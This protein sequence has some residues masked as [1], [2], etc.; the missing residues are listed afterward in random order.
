M[1]K[2]PYNVLLVNLARLY[3]GAEVRVL[4]LAAALQD[5]VE[6]CSVAVLQG[7]ALHVR[8][9]K[10][11]LPF[12]S[13]PMTRS[14]PR[15]LPAL[16]NIIRHG[17]YQIVDAHNVQSIL[18]GHFSGFA[19]GAKGRVTTVHSDFGAET[20]GIKGKFYESVLLLDRLLARQFVN[21]TEV[22]QIKAGKHRLGARSTLIPNAVAVPEPVTTETDFTIR[23]EW[24]FENTDFVVGIVARL[25]PIKGHAYLIEAMTLLADLPCIKL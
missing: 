14:N 22:L 15:L 6:N 12:V 5:S 2:R 4:T 9:Q 7:S 18:W 21:V 1:S 24:G 17:N 23:K 10:A 3:G 20:A 8:M 16:R 19:A 11:N 25:H 13:I